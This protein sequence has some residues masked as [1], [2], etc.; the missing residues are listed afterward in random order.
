VILKLS[1]ALQVSADMLLFGKDQR[2]LDDGLR[3]QF[4][5]VSP[6]GEEEKRV[7]RSLP[8]GMISNTKG[9]AGKLFPT[10]SR[11]LH[12]PAA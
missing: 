6:F 7:V 12:T 5:A 4:E 1:T 9:A 8:E 10:S 2:R 3:V 11:S